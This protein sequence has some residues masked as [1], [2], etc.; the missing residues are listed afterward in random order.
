[1]VLLEMFYLLKTHRKLAG[2]SK[3]SCFWPSRLRKRKLC[4]AG[5]R[6]LQA[7]I[8]CCNLGL[9]NHW[10]GINIETIRFAHNHNGGIYRQF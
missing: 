1:M 5:I 6:P 2:P 8:A 9:T 10:A 3:F 4:L 7:L